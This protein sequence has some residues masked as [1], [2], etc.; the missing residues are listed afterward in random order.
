ML[1][2]RFESETAP[3][4]TLL[5]LV[6]VIGAFPVEKL[7]VP[8]TV[9]GPVS[10]SAPLFVD[11][12]PAIEEVPNCKA[13]PDEVEIVTGLLPESVIETAPVKLLLFVK[14]IIPGAVSDVVPGIVQAPVWEIDPPLVKNKLP[15]TGKVNVPN[16]TLAALGKFKV[17]LRNEGKLLIFVGR[18]A[19]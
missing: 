14:L 8:E 7:D 18:M 5:G 13:N 2:P 12:L 19:V 9:M 6:K 1:F 4:K 17:K 15:V 16:D 10:E 11:K 3:T